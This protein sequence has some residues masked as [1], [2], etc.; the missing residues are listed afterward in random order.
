MILGAYTRLTDAGL[1]CPD[2]PG[3]YAQFIPVDVEHPDFEPD[4]AWTEMM[5]R[6]LAG[7][8]GLCVFLVAAL[9][10]KIQ[11]A[12]KRSILLVILVLFQALLG[13]WT[14]TLKLYPIVVMGH[15]M[16]GLS[17][18]SVL[19]LHLLSLKSPAASIPHATPKQAFFLYPLSLFVLLL[20]IFQLFLGGWTSANYAALVCLDFPTCQGTW[21]P[22][23]DFKQAFNLS[24]AGILDSPGEHLD[25]TARVTIQMMHRFGAGIVFIF[26]SLLSWLTRDKRL[27]FVLILQIILGITNILAV[28]PLSIAVLHHA[29]G[30]LLLLSLLSCCH[31]LCQKHPSFSIT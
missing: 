5:H 16:G 7:I 17:L 3:C 23:F 9:S 31:L 13:M 15:L 29:T 27:F 21:L 11:H 14:V 6:Y 1:G 20:L 22:D 4:K 25:Y 8:L 26:V 30:V 18:L 28:L 19:F 24:Q 2:W 10:I 12:Y